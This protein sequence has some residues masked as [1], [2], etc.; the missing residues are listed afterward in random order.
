MNKLQTNARKKYDWQKFWRLTVIKDLDNIR[1]PWWKSVRMAE[2]KCEC[3]IIKWYKLQRVVN[4]HTLSCWCFRK[5]S[6]SKRFAGKN[7]LQEQQ[8]RFDDE[9]ADLLEKV[10]LHEEL[11]S[12]ALKAII[13]LVREKQSLKKAN[14]MWKII[15]GIAVVG[16]IIL[17]NLI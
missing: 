11:I 7:C 5:E 1:S 4:W 6:T 17:I 16:Q 10:N 14:A 2:C 12:T 8:K 13:K 3:G 9:K 15:C